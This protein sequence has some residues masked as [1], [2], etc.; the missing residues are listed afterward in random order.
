MSFNFQMLKNNTVKLYSIDMAILL[1]YYVSLL[2][3]W[4][5]ERC[6]EG[7]WTEGTVIIHGLSALISK[8]CVKKRGD[9]NISL[10]HPY[11]NLG[12]IDKSKLDEYNWRKFMS[13]MFC[14]ILHHQHGFRRLP[15]SWS[16]GL[17]SKWSR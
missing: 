17:F 4:L 14:K 8:G 11:E 6:G 2:C 10:E 15:R 9:E 1:R 7:E 13:C 3:T 12:E 5:N 16:I